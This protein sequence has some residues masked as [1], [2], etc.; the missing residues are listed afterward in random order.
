MQPGIERR[1]DLLV[2]EFNL[3]KGYICL[4]SIAKKN[5]EYTSNVDSDA[6]L[7]C[8]FKKK[9][10]GVQH[11]QE[12]QRVILIDLS[13]L[14]SLYKLCMHMYNA[15]LKDIY[16]VLI[17]S[18]Q[19]VPS[20]LSDTLASIIMNIQLKQLYLMLLVSVSTVWETNYDVTEL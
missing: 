7:S 15:L 20:L 14:H 19:Q 5:N 4:G 1:V 12:N 13:E 17:V 2:V 8:D 6:I 9:F 3:A 18:L 16:Y 10:K 11:K